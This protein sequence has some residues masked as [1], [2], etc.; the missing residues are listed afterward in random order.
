MSTRN[1]KYDPVL[2]VFVQDY[3]P[4]TVDDFSREIQ[5][6]SDSKKV[7]D[8]LT[9]P[10]LASLTTSIKKKVKVNPDNYFSKKELTEFLTEFLNHMDEKETL[11]AINNDTFTQW[12]KKAKYRSCFYTVVV[13]QELNHPVCNNLLQK[14]QVRK[15]TTIHELTKLIINEHN[16]INVVIKLTET[17]INAIRHISISEMPILSEPD[18][19]PM[20]TLLLI[21]TK[22]TSTMPLNKIYDLAR[23]IYNRKDNKLSKTAIADMMHLNRR[24]I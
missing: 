8:R 6:S 21:A 4:Y 18:I 2:D 20:E 23:L 9:P 13:L 17:L 14:K 24:N 16:H 22:H 19:V 15:G 12:Y 11:K 7:I 5:S 10:Q 3:T 1:L